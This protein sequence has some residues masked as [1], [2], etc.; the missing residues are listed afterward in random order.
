MLTCPDCSEHLDGV[1]VG[2]PCTRCG[3]LRR[4]ATLSLAQ[5]RAIDRVF[6]AMFA[7]SIDRLLSHAEVSD[8]MK[9]TGT[10]TLRFTPPSQGADW[11]LEALGDD[12]L[13][14]FAPGPEFDD[15]NDGGS[16]ADEETPPERLPE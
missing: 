2:D 12:G 7:A 9:A 3:S 10:I 5:S 16:D 4:D 11:L 6:P 8:E 14:A 15:G 13:L 1:P